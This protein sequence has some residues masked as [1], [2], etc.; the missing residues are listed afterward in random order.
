MG[1]HGHAR[2]C[3][4]KNGRERTGNG[5]RR[6]GARVACVRVGPCLSVSVRVGLP[7][8]SFTLVERLVCLGRRLPFLHLKNICA[9][10]LRGGEGLSIVGAW[11]ALNIAWRTTI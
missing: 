10:N 3:T 8:A 6:T 7:T 2:A 4:G 11:T 9:N 5:R 1:M